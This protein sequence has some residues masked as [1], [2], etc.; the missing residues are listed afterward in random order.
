M[1]RSVFIILL[2]VLFNLLPV[3]SCKAINLSKSAEIS[4]LTCD[5]G[6]ELYSIFG[7]SAI[8][9]MDPVNNIDWVYNYG[10]FDFETEHFY[11]KFAGGR[12][13]Y[14][15]NTE[16]YMGFMRSYI[17]ENRTVY[18]QTLNLDSLTKQK[19]FDLLEENS[20]KENRNYR[21]EF[22]YDNCTTRIRDVMLKVFDNKI[23]F[24][25]YS[26]PPIPTY[27]KM[28]SHYINHLK[29]TDL[30]IDLI[31]GLPADHK[32]I[33]SE[34]MFLPK[35]LMEAFDKAK[36]NN[37]STK[38]VKKTK[39]LFTASKTE[40]ATNEVISPRLF[41]WLLF[42]L[43]TLI[44]LFEILK[45]RNIWIFDFLLFL[46][47]GLLGLVILS[48]IL[49][50]TYISVQ[51]NMVLLWAIPFHFFMAFF[52]ARKRSKFVKYYFF[53]TFIFMILLLI[54]WVFIPQELNMATIPLVLLI[55][56]RAFKL[57]YI[58]SIEKVKRTNIYY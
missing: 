5:P 41:F 18:E 54:S 32:M 55:A 16:E 2:F 36:I 14:Y 52:V 57:Y 43:F 51:N 25:Q 28:I 37:D 50:S 24:T 10:T 12:L 45:R 4:L 19:L 30:G 17:Y 11:L 33:K 56:I 29:W 20:K 1:M 8:R 44:T 39:I 26:P 49:G 46:V 15:L 31:F 53:F 6:E 35:E 23:D 3:A 9:V 58:K 42:A 47:T 27:R 21:Y 7:H 34:Y 48:L 38:L 40:N 13:L 22:F